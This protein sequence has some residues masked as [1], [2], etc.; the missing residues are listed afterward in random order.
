MPITCNWFGFLFAPCPQIPSLMP[1]M[2]ESQVMVFCRVL[3]FVW[4]FWCLRLQNPF[5]ATFLVP[6][7]VRKV[8]ESWMSSTPDRTKFSSKKFTARIDI[9]WDWIS[10]CFS[11]MCFIYHSISWFVS[12]LSFW[13]YI[14]IVPGTF[15]LIYP[16]SSFT[17]SLQQQQGQ[18]F[19]VFRTQKSTWRL[20][21]SWKK[22]MQFTWSL[23]LCV[24]RH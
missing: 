20:L 24:G 19:G 13:H 11:S 16:Y 8:I 9:N 15:F 12:V 21:P 2:I 23:Y 5:F 10:S 22:Q 18:A 1:H 7:Q 6:L 4:F 3:F 17:W 14:S